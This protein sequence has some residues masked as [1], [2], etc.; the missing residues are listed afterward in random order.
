MGFKSHSPTC[1]QQ[2]P[3][4]QSAAWDASPRL[5]VGHMASTGTN[6]EERKRIRMKEN[7]SRD[8]RFRISN[9]NV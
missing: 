6:P 2:R 7:S 8:D 5:P 1:H 9:L 3:A 4:R